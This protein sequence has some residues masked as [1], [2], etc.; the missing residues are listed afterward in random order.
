MYLVPACLP[1]MRMHC[2]RCAGREYLQRLQR[3]HVSKT[4][5]RNILLNLIY[6]AGTKQRTDLLFTNITV[7]L[8]TTSGS[9]QQGEYSVDTDISTLFVIEMLQ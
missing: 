1:L 5:G 2:A 7:S 9:A 6:G 8:W 3:G 4:G